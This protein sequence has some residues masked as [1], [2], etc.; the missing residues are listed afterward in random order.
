[1]KGYIFSI[2]IFIIISLL[3]TYFYLEQQK[4][5]YQIKNLSNSNKVMREK[6]E[7]L[8]NKD[9]ITLKKLIITNTLGDKVIELSS[10]KSHGGNISVFNKYHT[11][12]IRI[13]GGNIDGNAG[14]LLFNNNDKI[15]FAM[16]GDEEQN[17]FNIYNKNK[18]DTVSI[19]TDKHGHGG[20]TI[21]NV[22]EK[23][24]KTEGW[25]WR[26]YDYKK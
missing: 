12:T 16:M 1:M 7:E 11:R 19:G 25:G 6:I 17:L 15:A 18:L 24:I 9:L 8:T 26:A 3:G 14:I 20:Y 4:I 23:V 10:N 22:N 13:N 2:V 5:N 21:K